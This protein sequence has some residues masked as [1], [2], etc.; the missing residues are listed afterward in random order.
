MRSYSAGLAAQDAWKFLLGAE[1]ADR[2][3]DMEQIK[4]KEAEYL[5]AVQTTFDE[6]SKVR[7]EVNRLQR[8]YSK[9]LPMAAYENVIGAYLHNNPHAEF[10]TNWVH[11]CTPFVLT[12]SNRVDVY[13]CFKKLVEKLD[14][15]MKEISL[16]DRVISFQALFRRTMPD[17]YEYFEEEQ[18]CFYDWVPSWIGFLLSKEL[19]LETLLLLW[20]FYFSDVNFMETHR[21]FC[22]AILRQ[23]KE[24]LEEAEH[25]E[26]R[27]F[28]GRL[29]PMD[30]FM[31][32]Q[33][34][35]D[36]RY[37]DREDHPNEYDPDVAPVI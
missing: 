14:N 13:H 22:L 35:I 23:Y 1:G 17:L 2:T 34:A 20:D 12:M 37:K 18:V 25:S 5:N 9:P 36:L 24:Y 27:G 30:I 26:I 6:R 7:T 4:A 21:F 16:N 10:S 11:L 29:P 31:I 15:E 32:W 8:R 33:M 19:S 28:L 3:N